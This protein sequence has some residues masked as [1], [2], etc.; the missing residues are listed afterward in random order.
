MGVPFDETIGVL[1]GPSSQG[2]DRGEG[3]TRD[4]GQAESTA[5]EK[6]D[7]GG[8]ILRHWK[9]GESKN[10]GVMGGVLVVVKF[11]KGLSL[12]VPILVRLTDVLVAQH[13]VARQILPV[14]LR[15]VNGRHR[16]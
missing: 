11:K 7:V 6:G 3:R 12:S 15:N 16:L 1:R 9:G 13:L 5:G 10:A 14:G 8:L 2:V 4:P